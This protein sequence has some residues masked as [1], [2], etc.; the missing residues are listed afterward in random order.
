[1]YKYNNLEHAAIDA[2][3]LKLYLIATEAATKVNLRDEIRSLNVL[4]DSLADKAI[5][6]KSVEEYVKSG[7]NN[8]K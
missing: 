7:L 2:S 1:M 8:E 5:A 6:Y 4:H 3:R